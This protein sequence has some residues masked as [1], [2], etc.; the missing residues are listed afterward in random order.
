MFEIMPLRS[1]L[2]FMTANQ[3]LQSFT[4]GS[5]SLAVFERLTLLPEEM[6]ES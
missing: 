6:L 2:E 3:L 1:D 4:F 5:W